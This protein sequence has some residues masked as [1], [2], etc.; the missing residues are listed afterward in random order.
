[1]IAGLDGFAVNLDD[2]AV[3]GRTMEEHRQNLEEHTIQMTPTN[4]APVSTNLQAQ[5]RRLRNPNSSEPNEDP[6]KTSP[7]AEAT[8]IPTPTPPR[9]SK[10]NRRPPIRRQPN[11][12][13]L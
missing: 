8:T 3:T 6:L 1:M 2:I 4:T 9:R 12:K 10:R 11:A 7:D 13:N 5:D